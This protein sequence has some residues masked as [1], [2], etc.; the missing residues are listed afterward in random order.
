[1]V[2][3]AKLELFPKAK[4]PNVPSCAAVMLL[5]NALIGDGP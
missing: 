4:M 5:L 1:V 3:A 2:V